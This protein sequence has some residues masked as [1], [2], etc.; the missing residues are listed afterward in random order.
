MSLAIIPLI[1]KEHPVHEH[2]HR[3]QEIIKV[4]T[5][6]IHM[7]VKYIFIEMTVSIQL[8]RVGVGSVIE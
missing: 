4:C 3:R 1:L 8:C 5:P 7:T 2:E 6:G